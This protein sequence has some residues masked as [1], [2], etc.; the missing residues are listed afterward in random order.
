MSSCQGNNYIPNKQAGD[1]WGK[2]LLSGEEH[3]QKNMRGKKLDRLSR[4]RRM[5]LVEL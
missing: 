4:D 2:K 5:T 3:R 1:D